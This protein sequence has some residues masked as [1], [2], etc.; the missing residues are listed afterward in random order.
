MVL[1]LSCYSLTIQYQ[2]VYVMAVTVRFKK[3]ASGSRSAYLD[4]CDEGNRAYEFLD[5]H[6]HK[7]DPL[8]K[9]KLKLVEQVRSMR[10]VELY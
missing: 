3:L 9:D 1:L 8:K 10:E 2:I 4:V 7:N 5:I 6:I